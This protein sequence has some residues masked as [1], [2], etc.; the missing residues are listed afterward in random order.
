[1][2]AITTNSSIKENTVLSHLE[3]PPQSL[4][5]RF[6]TLGPQALYDK[7][8]VALNSGSVTSSPP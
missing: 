4:R 5:K 1:M 8:V 2:I 6:R 7:N 3:N